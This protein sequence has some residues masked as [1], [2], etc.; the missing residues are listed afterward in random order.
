MTVPAEIIRHS[1]ADILYPVKGP[2]QLL[3]ELLAGSQQTQAV[4]IGSLQIDRHPVGELHRSQHLV[5]LGA[6]HDL[7]VNVPAVT[8]LAAQDLCSVDELVL[9]AD[10]TTDD[11]GA[12]E[13]ALGDT[14]IENIHVG[15][16][17]FIG[18]EGEAAH[19]PPGTEGA[20]VA[21]TLA[22]RCEQ[23]LEQRDTLAVGENCGTEVKLIRR[24]PV[25]VMLRGSLLSQ[26]GAGSLLGGLEAHLGGEQAEAGRGSP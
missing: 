5:A 22:G 16:G 15:A 14:A 21:V 18:L 2:N 8:Q 10:P 17:K 24:L 12:E 3:G 13:D 6:W 9:G 19:I 20:V 7:Q 4:S 11:A 23:G 1:P 26:L 25:V